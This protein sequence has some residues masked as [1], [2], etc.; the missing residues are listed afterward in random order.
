MK[1]STEQL[2]EKYIA[3][4]EATQQDI[5]QYCEFAEDPHT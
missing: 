3:T 4:G 2:A 1:M 5:A